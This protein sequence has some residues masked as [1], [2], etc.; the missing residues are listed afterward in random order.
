MEEQ[1]ISLIK[2][3]ELRKEETNDNSELPIKRKQKYEYMEKLRII[4][5]NRVKTLTIIMTALLFVRED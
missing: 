1:N 3:K 5:K 4:I 2:H